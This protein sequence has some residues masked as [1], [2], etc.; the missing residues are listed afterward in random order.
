MIV[1]KMHDV[2]EFAERV[3][4]NNCDRRDRPFVNVA[5]TDRDHG[6]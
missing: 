6:I 2:A 4:A 3:T 1:V 5:A